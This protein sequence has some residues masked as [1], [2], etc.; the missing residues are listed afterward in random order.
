VNVVTEVDKS[1]KKAIG[2]RD[3]ETRS[4]MNEEKLPGKSHSLTLEGILCSISAKYWRSG[5]SP[6]ISIL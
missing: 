6:G 2:L 4:S 1:T 3:F 5:D